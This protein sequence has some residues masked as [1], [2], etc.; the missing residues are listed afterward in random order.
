MKNKTLSVVFIEQEEI[1]FTFDLSFVPN[2]VKLE[3]ILN[4]FRL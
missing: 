1:I 3:M 2:L 4:T